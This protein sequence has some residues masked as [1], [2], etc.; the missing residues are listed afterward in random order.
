MRADPLVSVLWLDL[1]NVARDHV[2]LATVALSLRGTLVIA[3]VGLAPD[4]PDGWSDAFPFV[5][6]L[7]LVTGPAAFGFLFGSLMVD[8]AD[9]GVRQALAVTPVRP[10]DLLLVRTVIATA[11][12]C[13]WPLASVY[14]MNAT[15]RV[16]DLSLADWLTVIVPLA[17]LTPGCTL[18]I[19]TLA[20]D[21]VSALAVLKALSFLSLIPLALFLVPSDAPYGFAFL[22]LPTAWTV[23]AYQ[24]LLAADGGAV[25]WASGGIAYAIA[26]LL[27][28]RHYF[29]WNVYRL[30]D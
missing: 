18:L 30:Y 20:R 22:L 25:A 14:L 21:K 8:E 9:T 4:R 29:E 23:E 27:M 16:L 7:G 2:A 11:W 1:R 26:L 28:V 19:P 13:A 17:L 6:A 5:V 12:M 3:G 10:R 15:W 24:A